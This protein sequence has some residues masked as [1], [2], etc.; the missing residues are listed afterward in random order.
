MIDFIKLKIK[1]ILCNHPNWHESGGNRS[2]P[3]GIYIA[4]ECVCSS[5]GKRIIE[6]L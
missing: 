1:Q 6:K 2:N 5:C 3:M 4:K